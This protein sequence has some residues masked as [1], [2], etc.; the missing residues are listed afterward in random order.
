MAGSFSLDISKF[1][2]KAPECVDDIIK[3]VCFDLYQNFVE[4]TP[5]DTGRAKGG[6]AIGVNQ[7]RF[8]PKGRCAEPGTKANIS[9]GSMFGKAKSILAEVKGDCVVYVVNNVEYIASLEYGHSKQRPHGMA[10]ITLREY[11]SYLKKH[12]ATL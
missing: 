7:K 11:S 6:W 2:K 5:C 4:R 9:T 1:V 10:R 3:K 8:A 12:A